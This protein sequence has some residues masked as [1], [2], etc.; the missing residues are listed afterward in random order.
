MVSLAV[1]GRGPRGTNGGAV[2]PR[3]RGRGVYRALVAARLELA[4]AAGLAGVAVQ[5]MPDTSAPIL[6]W[7]GFTEV[8]RL[9]VFVATAS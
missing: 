3:F 1:P 6:A 8:G 7:L 9:Q 2:A 5:A 4:R